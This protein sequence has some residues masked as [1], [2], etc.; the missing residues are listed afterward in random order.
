MANTYTK[1]LYHLIWSTKARAPLIRA[2]IE[3][4]VWA[5]LAGIA[6]SNDIHPI[7]IG[8]VEDHIHALLEI[9]KTLAVAEA[10]KRLKGG[11]STWIHSQNLI[12][13]PFHWQ[14]GYAAFTVSVSRIEKV[15]RYIAEQREHH[16]HTTFAEEYESFLEAHGI[17]FDAQYHLG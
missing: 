7:R 17:Q 16:Q 8:G 12:P 1:L 13:Q 3:E 9:P 11:S 6:H 4:R 10:V 14:D 2:D 15:Q 5:Y